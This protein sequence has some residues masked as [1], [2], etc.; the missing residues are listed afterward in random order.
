[1]LNV[2]CDEDV[3]CTLGIV[4]SRISIF[5][6]CLL[7]LANACV[8]YW[9]QHGNDDEFHGVK[10]WRQWLGSWWQSLYVVERIVVDLCVFKFSCGQ[11]LHQLAI[12][13]L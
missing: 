10:G 6:F 8:N 5:F 1:V 3:A 9:E 7:S 2:V 12:L 11:R 13:G 4:T